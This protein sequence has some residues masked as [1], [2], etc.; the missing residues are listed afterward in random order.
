MIIEKIDANLTI[1][2]ARASIENDKI[3]SPTTKAAFESLITL[4]T[5]LLNRIT[6]NSSN[7]SKP[8]S[9]D[10]DNKNKKSRRKSANPRGGQKGHEGTNLKPVNDPDKIKKRNHSACLIIFKNNLT[11]FIP[12]FSFFYIINNVG[13]NF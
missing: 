9:T 4:T 6:L 11:A 7:S 3:I 8:P 12:P 1:K 10:G 2:T 13:F 5:A